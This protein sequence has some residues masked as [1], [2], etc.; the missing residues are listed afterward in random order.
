MTREN[1]L[2]MVIGFGLL[3]F[4]GILVSDHLSARESQIANPIEV[5]NHEPKTPLP[6]TED[7]MARRFGGDARGE[8]GQ[9]LVGGTPLTLPVDQQGVPTLGASPVPTPVVPAAPKERIHTVAK[10]DNPEKIASKYYNRRS[11][12]SKLAEYNGIDPSK[13]K[14]GQTLKIPDI[15]VLDPSAAPAL[16]EARGMQAG[17]DQTTQQTTQQPSQQPAQVQPMQP[18]VVREEPKSAEARTSGNAAESKYKTVKVQKG[19]TLW[20]LAARSYGKGTNAN[21]ARLREMNPGLSDKNLKVGSQLRIAL[22]N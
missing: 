19:D 8:N 12:A 9:A 22:A 15:A 11:L 3:L 7:E 21:V 1:K 2:V 17:L 18:P 5:V 14:I 10:G 4:V 20:R 13:L 6:L 16:P